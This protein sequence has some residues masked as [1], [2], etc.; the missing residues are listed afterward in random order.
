MP[1]RSKIFDNITIFSCIRGAETYLV[2]CNGLSLTSEEGLLSP[3]GPVSDGFMPSRHFTCQNYLSPKFFL[4]I[5]S[6]YYIF[7]PLE[8]YFVNSHPPMVAMLISS[9]RPLF[10][11]WLG[12]W[13]IVWI[14]VAHITYAL[15]WT[16]QCK[17]RYI[18][19]YH[20]ANEKS[21]GPH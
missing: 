14:I 4:L 15:V 3:P 19:L 18:I 16:S 2:Y 10:T 8:M 21:N 1:T 5:V 12:E 7:E 20:F 17:G 13:I 11:L 6:I 9:S